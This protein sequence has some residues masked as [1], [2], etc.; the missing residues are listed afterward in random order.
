MNAHGSYSNIG[1][2]VL[3]DIVGVLND[4]AHG[5]IIDDLGKFQVV[6]DVVTSPERG[7]M[8]EASHQGLQRTQTALVPGLLLDTRDGIKEDWVEVAALHKLVKVAVRIVAIALEEIFVHLLDK[9]A[10]AVERTVQLHL[11]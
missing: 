9:N 1:I 10:N 4:R 3:P 11:P 2:E 5:E 6:D 7:S 8:I